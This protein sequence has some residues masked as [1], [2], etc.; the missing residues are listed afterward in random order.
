MYD[1]IVVGARCA[2]AATATLLAGAGH[3]VLMVDKAAF[4]S[5]T[6][7]THFIHQP[8]VASLARW[9]LL[10]RVAA[11]APP[12]DRY[13]FDVGPFALRGAPPPADGHRTAFA[14]RRFFLDQILVDAAV[15]AGV[16]FRDRFAVKE[17][18]T[19]EGR[20]VGVRGRQEGG[21]TITERA[22]IVVGADGMRSVVAKAVGA[23]SYNGKP[24]FNC[25]Y[26]TYWS[27]VP[28]DGV[29][30]YLRPERMLIAA[31]TNDGLTLTIVYWPVSMFGQVKTH[32]EREFVDA[33][34][35]VP[36]LGERARAGRRAEKF[37]GSA[38]LEGYFRTPFGPGWA[39]V[40]DAGYHK[41]PITAEG[42]T[43]AFRDAELL[44]SAIDDALSGRAAE[45]DALS[46]YER[47]RNEAAMPIYELTAQLATLEPPPP[48][49]QALLGS[50][51]GDQDGIDRFLGTIAGTVPIPEFFG[52][53]S[54]AGVA[55]GSAS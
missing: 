47:A 55:G 2:G 54:L 53:A 45:A 24:A 11:G 32:I 3:R 34:D 50:L 15:A 49:M 41:N 9:G 22:T 10:D 21:S 44:A 38:Q 26:Y 4:P 5:D 8:G 29:E 12:I 36:S 27:D 35:I 23:A 6:L 30:L 20:V 17:V 39:L 52:A 18:V 16:E 37:R 33:L 40:G 48:E 19:D 1:V 31:P 14:P 28:V 46:G 7:S 51:Q 25:A 13:A 43:D 42:I